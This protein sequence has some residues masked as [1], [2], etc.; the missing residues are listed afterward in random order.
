MSDTND[1]NG[2]IN[3]DS[4][5]YV[6]KKFS[7]MGYFLDG[8]S[9]LIEGMG[10]KVDEVQKSTFEILHQR[11]M[12]NV[13]INKIK[14]YVSISSTEKRDYFGAFKS[15][16]FNTTIY[17]DQRGDDLFTSWKSYYIPEMN[18]N[19]LIILAAV[20]GVLSLFLAASVRFLGFWGWLICTIILFMLSLG[21]V[22]RLGRFLKGDPYFYL[23][24]QPNEFDAEDVTA[25]NL[26]IHKT[27]LRVLDSKGIDISKLRLKQD[28]K[29]GRRDENV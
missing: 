27:L 12:K 24:N 14:G 15:P 21:F 18:T 19:L 22:E 3:Y 5:G 23:T 11:K 8:W 28:F 29:G 6:E 7:Q 10:N 25:M 17:I 26:A 1:V 13:T 2:T 16:G 20:A 4:Q 9:D